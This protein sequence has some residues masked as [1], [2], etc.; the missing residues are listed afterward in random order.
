MHLKFQ[1]KKFSTK[2]DF[3]NEIP[4]FLDTKTKALFSNSLQRLYFLRTTMVHFTNLSQLLWKFSE[5]GFFIKELSLVSVFKVFSN[6][7]TSVSWKLPVGHILLYLLH[8][9]QYELLDKKDIYSI[10]SFNFLVS[11]Y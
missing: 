10:S 2:I 6:L 4:F 3:W 9:I 7:V 11:F 8:L 1:F 5:N